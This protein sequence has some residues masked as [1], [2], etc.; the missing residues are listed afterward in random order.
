MPGADPRRWCRQ[1]LIKFPLSRPLPP[2][3]TPF[4]PSC[5]WLHLTTRTKSL[6]LCPSLRCVISAEHTQFHNSARIPHLKRGM[7]RN[8]LPPITCSM[9]ACMPTL[10]LPKHHIQTWPP[11][12][13]G[14]LYCGCRFCACA[15]PQPCWHVDRVC[16]STLVWQ[17]HRDV[18]RGAGARRPHWPLPLLLSVLH[19]LCAGVGSLLPA[20]RPMCTTS[21]PVTAATAPALTPADWRCTPCRAHPFKQAPSR[22]SPFVPSRSPLTRPP[23]RASTCC[24]SMTC[25]TAASH[26]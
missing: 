10:S 21:Q 7:G 11:L 25:V 4:D 5:S 8:R 2:P 22:P 3:P 23:S 24:W 17:G 15:G 18:R 13:T 12:Y 20:T 9:R 14:R 6:L 26:C 16:V 1:R 19:V